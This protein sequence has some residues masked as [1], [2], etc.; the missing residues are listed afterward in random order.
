MK[1]EEDIDIGMT[2]TQIG[3]DSF[4]AIELRRWWKQ[5]SGLGISVLEIM[6]S[7]TLEGL[8]RVAGQGLKGKFKNR[9]K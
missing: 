5:A 6:P 2:L 4:M 9:E 8:G 1:P 7:G 3:M